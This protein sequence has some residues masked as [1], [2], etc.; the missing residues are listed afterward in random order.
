MRLASHPEALGAELLD[1][2]A[3]EPILKAVSREDYTSGVN[4]ARE[5]PPPDAAWAR[6]VHRNANVAE[7]EQEPATAQA[8]QSPAA[9]GAAAAQLPSI[10]ENE[11]LHDEEGE[12]PTARRAR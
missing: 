2:K 1:D 3:L 7:Y 9:P 12:L 11:P 8:P 5:G 4:V 6:E 10:P